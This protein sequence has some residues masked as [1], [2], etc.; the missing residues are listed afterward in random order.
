MMTA[1]ITKTTASTGAANR[2]NRCTRLWPKNA[3]AVCATTIRTRPSN[4]VIP[5]RVE[6]ANAPLTVGL[7]N[8]APRLMDRI[9][10]TV[11][12]EA[13]L[14][15]ETANSP[16][17]LREGGGEARV[18]G[19]D[20]SKRPTAPIAE[21]AMNSPVTASVVAA[22]VLGSLGYLVLRRR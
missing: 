4:G 16:G 13:Q 22:T 17:N 3:N 11:M 15:E 5:N 8:V 6:S 10:E 21:V 12:F 18:R 14:G 2:S 1:A 20:G 7:A 9:S 19:E